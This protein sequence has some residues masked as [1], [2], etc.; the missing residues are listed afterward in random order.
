MTDDKLKDAARLMGDHYAKG[1][2]EKTT[3]L[4]E[5]KGANGMHGYVSSFTDATGNPG[6]FHFLMAGIICAD[7]TYLAVT[8]YCDDRN[9]D[10]HTAAL[11]AVKNLSVSA[12]AAPAKTISTELKVKSPDE[13][14]TLVVPGHWKV[15]EDDKSKDRTTREVTAVADDGVTMLSLFFDPP[16]KATGD[17]SDARAYYLDRMK[18]YRKPLENLKQDTTGEF[19]TLEYDQGSEGFKL[20]NINAYLSH[21]GVWVDVHISKSDFNEKTDRAV[22]D[23]ILKGLKR[24]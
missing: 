21:N 13:T 20:H 8:L 17:A 12:G 11:E 2:K 16:I 1:S 18:I 9:S 10:D 4:E 22:F 15:M 3:A 24:E 5:F 7:K 14:W 19:A 6:A 23:E